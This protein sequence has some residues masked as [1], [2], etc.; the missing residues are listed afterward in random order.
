M[1]LTTHSTHFKR[2]AYVA[3]VGFSLNGVSTWPYEWRPITDD[4][5]K[6]NVFQWP[7]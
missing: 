2:V 6:M 3:A 7:R 1:Y 5:I 4:K